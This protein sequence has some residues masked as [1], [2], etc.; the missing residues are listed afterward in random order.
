MGLG[1]KRKATTA[2]DL[3]ERLKK[4]TVVVSLD[5][6]DAGGVAT[7]REKQRLGIA[8]DRKLSAPFRV[9]LFQKNLEIQKNCV[10]CSFSSYEQARKEKKLENFRHSEMETDYGV[11]CRGCGHFQ[12]RICLQQ[13]HELGLGPHPD[14]EHLKGYLSKQEHLAHVPS[15]S[16]CSLKNKFV[17]NIPMVQ[18]TPVEPIRQQWDGMLWFPEYGLVVPSSLHTFDLHALAQFSPKEKGVL[19][20]VVSPEMAILL[21]DAGIKAMGKTEP[22][23]CS[24]IE[25]GIWCHQRKRNRK[26]KV[27]LC[28]YDRC[29]MDNTDKR[30][31]TD[32]TEQEAMEASIVLTDEDMKAARVEGIDIICLIGNPNDGELDDRFL[33]VGRVLSSSKLLGKVKLDRNALFSSLKVKLP[34]NGYESRRYGG[35]S[36]KPRCNDDFQVP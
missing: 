29:N 21:E 26:V 31:G 27:K 34:R 5:A 2:F 25:V 13:L 12:C 32:I 23:K 16:C 9:I 10:F 6:K 22:A 30:L 24:T 7:R 4:L 33:L 1:K 18:S 28:L 35:S 14:F 36:G 20:G 19:H 17:K 11:Q 3:G 8:S 15:C